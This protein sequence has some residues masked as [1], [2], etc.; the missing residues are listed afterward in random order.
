M[1]TGSVPAEVDGC[2]AEMIALEDDDVPDDDMDTLFFKEGRGKG[3]G[4]GTGT[5]FTCLG[6]RGSG[7]GGESAAWGVGC[8]GSEV[9]GCP[10]GECIRRRFAT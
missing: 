1:S 9:L 10:S 4:R 2:D 6:V 7:L 8:T 3:R 5:G